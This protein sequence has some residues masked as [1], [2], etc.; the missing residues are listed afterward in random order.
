MRDAETH[1]ATGA[2]RTVYDLN[3]TSN[4]QV[5]DNDWRYDADV[6]ADSETSSQPR[7]IIEDPLSSAIA[8][9][10]NSPTIGTVAVNAA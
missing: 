7:R 4:K 2:C 5:I 1:Q 6:V 8:K 3:D 10:A 9:S